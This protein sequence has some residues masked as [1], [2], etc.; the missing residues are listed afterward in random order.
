MLRAGVG[1]LAEPV[2]HAAGRLAAGGPVEADVD[3]LVR[4][5]LDLVEVAPDP[6]AVLAQDGVLVGDPG[7][8]TEDVRGVR[9]LRD[10]AE[11]LLLAAAADEDGHSR[12]ARSTGAS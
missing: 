6:L 7:T 12:A 4:R 9:V 2:D 8:V 5:P 3:V 11:G 1:E 10:E